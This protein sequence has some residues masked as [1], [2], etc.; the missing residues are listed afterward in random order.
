MTLSLQVQII[1][2]GLFAIGIPFFVRESPRWLISR[3]R[4]DEAIKNLS[5]LRKLPADD[6]Y[7]IQEMYAHSSRYPFLTEAHLASCSNDIDLQVEN[8]RTAVGTG[9]WAPF[10]QVFGKSFLF[11]RLLIVTSLFMWQ[12][13]TGINAVNY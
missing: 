5:F 3:S 13:A 6:P 11:R 2:S 9:F 1:P 4:R 7:M 8:D 10:R 12:N